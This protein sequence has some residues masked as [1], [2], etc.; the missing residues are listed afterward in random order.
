VDR[1]DPERITWCEFMEWLEAE[2]VKR[3]KMHDAGLH[4]TGKTRILGDGATYKLSKSRMEYTIEHML[5]IKVA[6]DMEVLLVIFEND[7][8]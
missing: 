6:S 7:V 8:A 5:A 1:K 2:G 3:E 4:D